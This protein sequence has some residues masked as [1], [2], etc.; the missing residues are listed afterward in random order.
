MEIKICSTQEWSYCEWE[1]FVSSFEAIFHKGFTK[2]YFNNKYLSVCDRQSYHALLLHEDK[3]VGNISVIPYW[4]RHNEDELIKIGLAADVFILEDYRSDPF[5]LRRMYKRL[6]TLLIEKRIVSVMAVPNE[7]AYSYWKNVVKWQDVGMIKYWGMPVRVG[8]I[9][10]KSKLLNVCSLI[11]VYIA[12]SISFVLSALCRSSQKKFQYEIVD[13]ESFLQ[14]RFSHDDYVQIHHR[15]CMNCFRI[16]DEQGVRTAY[17]IYSRQKKRMSFLSLYKGVFSILKEHKVDLIL[18]VGPLK[19]FQT[20]FLCI[21][22]NFE[23]KS[24]P[25]TCDLLIKD[26]EIHKDMLDFDK[27]DFGLLNYDVR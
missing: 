9:M 26:D 15:N 4:Y 24:L 2:D 8:N 27:W 14:G 18:Y 5:T 11:Y 12:V 22:Q 3:V 17:L 19:L 10:R 25:L 21:P 6:T 20:L 7:T 16:V 23:P 1:S 13:D